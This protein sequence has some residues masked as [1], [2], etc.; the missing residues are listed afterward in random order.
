M[1]ENRLAITR[2]GTLHRYPAREECN[3]DQARGLHVIAEGE[4]PKRKM[5]RRCG[6]CF[7][8]IVPEPPE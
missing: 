7:V 2:S 5:K 6:Y 3:L 4:K 1:P 8:S